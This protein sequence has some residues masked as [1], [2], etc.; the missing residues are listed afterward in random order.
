MTTPL[1][2][3]AK[4]K[5]NPFVASANAA[6]DDDDHA[7]ALALFGPDAP[8]ESGNE[9]QP[10]RYDAYAML[11]RRR[12]ALDQLPGRSI[13]VQR[14]RA[15]LWRWLLGPDPLRLE[16][17]SSA[18]ASTV[19]WVVGD[20]DAADLVEA[21]LRGFHIDPGDVVRIDASLA[22]LTEELL[23]GRSKSQNSSKKPRRKGA[24][25]DVHAPLIVADARRD[26]SVLRTVCEAAAH[27]A[28]VRLG[29]SETRAFAARVAIVTRERPAETPSNVVVFELPA[30][31]E[32]PAD[33][34]AT[35]AAHLKGDAAALGEPQ[36]HSVIDCVL[37]HKT[38]LRGAITR[39]W[40]SLPPETSEGAEP[41]LEVV[42]PSELV[43]GTMTLE[44]ARM[45]Y[46]HH[47]RATCR[48]DREAARRLAITRV[49]LSR[50]LK[51]G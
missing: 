22:G 19:L 24:I 2:R 12:L 46:A 45:W 40:A 47:V 51:G 25:E 35:L 50:L 37:A 20:D 16:D 43:M 18:L 9:P 17:Y 15:T 5:T 49:T 41:Q 21:A 36:R 26:A 13:S 23:F 32:R 1:E 10:A 34:D 38:D 39:A 6:L 28:Y 11:E 14:L 30:L 8:L 7:A 3:V 33:I 48:S 29:S 27:R 31:H 42:I 4:L 44:Q